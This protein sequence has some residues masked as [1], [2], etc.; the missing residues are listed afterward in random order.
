[1]RLD[2]RELFA[3][4]FERA[5]YLTTP[6][7]SCR[8]TLDPDPFDG[9]VW[10]I[11]AFYE[12]SAQYFDRPAEF[13]RDFLD[14]RRLALRL[15]EGDAGAARRVFTFDSPVA[16]R[17][18]ENARVPVVW[19]RAPRPARAVALLVPG[20]TRPDRRLEERW[21]RTLA[22]C[23]TDVLLL[24]VPYH[25]ERAP[26]GTWSGEYFISQNVFWTVAN[27][28]Q[29]V[30]EIR[31]LVRLVRADYDR[32]GLIGVSS[33]G[34]QA[35]LAT[36]G[37]DVDFLFPIMTGAELGAIAWESLL[38]HE[39]KAALIA[40]GV[41][42]DALSRAWS[43]TDLNVVGRHSLA[44]RMRQYVTLY[45]AV[46]PLR[47]QERLWHVY[48]EPPRVDLPTSHYS[49]VFSLPRVLRE[50]ASTLLAPDEERALDARAG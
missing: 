1:M 21:C 13:F 6:K 48:G 20:W 15:A 9:R 2:L 47:Y 42:R 5:I 27:F 14:G 17:F 34:F 18:A 33:G 38:T 11:D 46:M 43:I 23:G 49:A 28:R 24:T 37:E 45:D 44:R 26:S 30:A 35:G 41:S 4:G 36:L 32:V 16:S 8:V 22:E 25:L 12:W 29:L 40:R 39:V 10:T 31:A 3:R 7:R 50:I 19:F